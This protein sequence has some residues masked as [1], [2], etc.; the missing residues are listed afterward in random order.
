MKR[1]KG[2]L[3]V[4]IQQSKSKTGEGNKSKTGEGGT[5]KKSH[6]KKQGSPPKKG[7]AAKANNKKGKAKKRVMEA[8]AEKNDGA[9]NKDP[10]R[11][12]VKV[13]ERDENYDWKGKM[14]NIRNCVHAFSKDY[15]CQL[16]LCPECLTG[17]QMGTSR[18]KRIKKNDASAPVKASSR[19]KSSGKKL[20]KGQKCHHT[21]TDFMAILQMMEDRKYLK[22]NRKGNPEDYEDVVSHCFDCGLR[23]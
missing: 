13:E 12:L 3:R 9:T 11:P 17:R 22:R 14:L 15:P 7:T 20:A 1:T 16:A 23:F 4:Y 6:K 18:S 2:I 21:V 19:Q 5:N 8:V 10:L